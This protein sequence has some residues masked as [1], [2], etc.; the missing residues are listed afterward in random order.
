ML[1]PAWYANFPGTTG[2]THGRERMADGLAAA[3]GQLLPHTKTVNS[4]VMERRE[5]ADK[6]TTKNYKLNVKVSLDD[7]GCSLIPFRKTAG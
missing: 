3:A 6:S 7:F 4:K 2:K 5:W 1:S